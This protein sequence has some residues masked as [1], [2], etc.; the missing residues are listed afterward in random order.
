MVVAVGRPMRVLTA[1]LLLGC[2]ACGVAVGQIPG[3]PAG[4]TAPMVTPERVWTW[5]PFADAFC[6]NGEATGVAVNAL[7]TSKT[8][9]LYLQGGGACWDGATCFG[10]VPSAEHI[11]GGYGYPELTREENLWGILPIQ[12]D[13][14]DNPFAD[15]AMAFVPYCTG[16]VHVGT[17]ATRHRFGFE[18]R[19]IHHVGATNLDA[20][21]KRLVPTFPLVTRVVLAGAS[22]GG[23]GAAAN[24]ERVQLAFSQARVDVLDDSGPLINPTA[25]RLRQW[26]AAWQIAWPSG[27]A[28]CADGPTGLRRHLMRR[29]PD[30]HVAL[31][32]YES[33][34]VLA[35]YTDLNPPQFE[36]ALGDALAAFSEARNHHVFV[37]PGSAHVVLAAPQTRVKGI[38]F[39]DWLG[40]FAREEAG[41]TSVIP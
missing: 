27:C 21:L 24:Q 31:A 32:V 2:G 20:F 1:F 35:Y 13:S 17:H 7:P 8:L 26:Q 4:S 41:W 29:F 36:A 6:A 34:S 5:V 23:F 10:P 9:V 25:G 11:R 33:D 12:R 22:A 3:E 40:A 30:A 16:D 14:A 38:A 39:K 19:T 15:A 37:V 28:D 18:E